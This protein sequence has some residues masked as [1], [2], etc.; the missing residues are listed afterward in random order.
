VT[1]KTHKVN[2]RNTVYLLNGKQYFRFY[3][4]RDLNHFTISEITIDLVLIDQ[5]NVG[6]RYLHLIDTV[7]AKKRWTTN[8]WRVNKFLKE[9]HEVTRLAKGQ[10]SFLK[11]NDINDI[12][13]F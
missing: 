7:N 8:Y 3:V 4:A 9:N 11:M 6:K 2:K 5:Q 12:L 13:F 1:Y 10:A